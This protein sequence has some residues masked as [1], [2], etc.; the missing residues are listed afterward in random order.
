MLQFTLT[1]RTREYAF[2]AL[3]LVTNTLLTM[4]KEEQI[5]AFSRSDAP[6]WFVMRDLKRNNAKLPAY[7]MLSEMKIEI[8]TPMKWKIVTKEKKRIP[9]KVPFMQDLLFVHVTRKVLDP[10][11]ERTSTLQYRYLRDGFRTPMTVRDTDMERFIRAVESA[12]NPQFYT[13]KDILPS[14]IGKTVRIIGGP[15]NDYV[16]KLQKMQGSKVK[17]IFIELS[18]LLTAS[19]EVQPEYIQIL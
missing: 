2:K 5:I 19:I 11:V 12:D 3:I 4:T 17:R 16:G 15:L 14:M 13:P 18:N 1:R 8:F 9:Q 10:I 6:Q 7:K